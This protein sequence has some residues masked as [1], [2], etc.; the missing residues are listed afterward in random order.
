MK[1]IPVA[2]IKKNITFRTQKGPKMNPIAWPK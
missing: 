1:N 2:N